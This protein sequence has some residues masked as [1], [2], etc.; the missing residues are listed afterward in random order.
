MKP[1]I[2]ILF[3]FISIISF[4]QKSENIFI[5]TLDGLR[6]Q[7]VFNGAADSMMLNKELAKDSSG[8]AEKFK[9]TNKEEARQKLMPFFWKSIVKEGVLLGDRSYSNKVNCTNR[10][11]FSYPGYSEILCGYSD[12]IINSNNKFFNPNITVLEWFNKNEKYKNKVAAFCSWDVF[13]YIINEPRSGIPVNCGFETANHANLSSNEKFLNTILPQFPKPWTTVRND[14]ITHHYM[15]EYVKQYHPKVVYISYGETDDF[16]H[17]GKYDQYLFSAHQSDRFIED[18]WNF[19]QSDYIYKDN[20]TII[21]TTDH[22]RG[23]SPMTEWKSH[24]NI[25]KGS[26]EIWIA[27]IGAGIKAEGHVKTNSQYFQSQVASTAAKL[28]GLD[29][30]T[31]EERIEKPINSII[32]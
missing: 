13:D 22:G 4:A 25:Y 24:G 2:S 21:I 20:T 14:A 28:I 5:I 30:T 8:I 12:P 26:S 16:A 11:W 32:K 9:A 19:V 17:D 1:I 31:L 15:L 29:Y 23:H 3:L 27:A 18:I 7:E 10:F 6:W